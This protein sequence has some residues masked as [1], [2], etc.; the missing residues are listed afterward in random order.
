MSQQLNNKEIINFI[1]VIIP[2]AVPKLLSYHLKFG[3]RVNIGQRVLVNVGR[4]KQYSAIVFR[5][6]QQKP[7]YKTKEVLEVLDNEPI[8]NLKQ[9]E[10]WAWI[11]RYYMTTLGE[12]M[13]AG[14]P[15]SLKL[16]SESMY[17][18]SINKY[19][20]KEL[21]VLKPSEQKIVDALEH[22]Q[23]M[24][25]KE[26]SDLLQIKYP[27]IYIKNLLNLGWIKDYEAHQEKYR[28]KTIQK[29]NLHSSLKN[30]ERLLEDA[31]NKLSKAPKQEELLLKFLHL[32]QVLSGKSVIKKK[33]L[34]DSNLSAAVLKGLVDKNIL[35]IE[36]I[37]HSRIKD[38]SNIS[39]KMPNLSDFQSIALKKIDNYFKNGTSLLL[40]GVTG[41]GKT[42]IYIQL[43]A[44]QLKKNKKILYL[45]PEIAITTQI[46]QRLQSFFGNRVG[47]YHSRFSLAE[48]TEL[49]YSMMNEKLHQYDIIL[50][51]RSAIFLPFKDLG[52]IIVDEEHETSY[53]QIDPSPRYNARD[54]AS[55]MAQ[56]HN[57]KLLLGS[58]TPSMEMMEL[59]EQKKIGYVVLDKRYHDV[60]MPEIQCADLKVAHKKKKMRGIFTPL[61][62]DAIQDTLRENKQVI[63]F[64]N[65]RG[66]APREMCMVCSWTPMCKKCDVSLT[67]HKYNPIMKC[68]YCGYTTKRVENCGACGSSKMSKLGIGTQKIEEEL[69][70]HLGKEIRVKRMDWDTTRKKTSFQNIID[71]FEQKEI[72]I[73]V[74]T[75]MVSKGLD[76]DHVG[77][78]G[79][80]QA[81]DLLHYPDFRAYER[82]FQLLTQVSG[83]SGRKNERGKVILQTFDPY[84]WVIK[85]VME[86]D[87][88][89]LY[90]QELADRKHFK[91]PP[92]FKL[93]KLVLTHKNSSYLVV[94]ANNL[95]IELKKRLGERVLGP[96]FTIIPRINNYY[97]QQILLKL[98]NALSLSK[99]KEFIQLSINGWSK[100]DINK[101]IRVKVDVDPM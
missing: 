73:L 60:S 3:I 11:S 91:Y 38:V 70:K 72:D 96:E 87:F 61:L 9:L 32:N 17:L 94:G 88:K 26:I 14:L 37:E 100:K 66:Y 30:D 79:V 24:N 68:H 97:N 75:Q 53:K 8:V 81:D 29:I 39:K 7:S 1:D 23:Q 54:V 12:V 42:E 56:I 50:G 92:Y 58:A 49:W 59:V 41:S 74:G 25:L 4:K 84:H 44:Q 40:H 80:M 93:I 89:S 99:V 95:T 18:P 55:K 16:N 63:L 35:E 10:L 82:C 65:R 20:D 28:K 31:F 6:Y 5:V 76:F 43:I 86:Y 45:L 27:H 33:L 2:I 36:N 13:I 78:V 51:A 71:Q 90:K 85:M 15:N 19:S 21:S 22:N 57:S 67:V 64:Q 83:R 98:E 101:S 69:F 62:L 34:S 52:L 46:I 47:V 77:L 48:R